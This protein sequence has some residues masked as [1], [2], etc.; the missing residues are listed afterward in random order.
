MRPIQA[1]DTVSFDGTEVTMLDQT[2]LPV[3]QVRLTI[4]DTPQMHEAIRSLRVRGAPAIGVAAAFGLW[5]GVRDLPD[6]L[7]RDEAEARLR[8][9]QTFLAG[10]RPTA[11][12][13]TWALE[14]CAAEALRAPGGTAA[15]KQAALDA[16]IRLRANE[17]A[18]TRQ[19]GE[20]GA[21]LLMGLSGV[22]THCN[23]GSAATV[24]L[25]TALAPIYVAAER[26]HLLRV[27]ADETRPLLQG[28]RITAWELQEAGVP[29]TVITDS[30]AAV[31][32]RQGKVG[33]VI[34]GC[35]RVAANGDVANKIGTYGVALL[36]RAH[37]LPFYVAGPTSTIDLATPDGDHIE[38]E[39]R[40]PHEVTHHGGVPMAPEGVDV[41][42]PAFDVTPA[43][44]V[45]A[46]ITEKGVVYPPYTQGLKDVKA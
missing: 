12:N 28:A 37:G 26:G 27:F 41:F 17:E 31:V 32:M 42:N 34:V 21:G 8:G 11:V 16:A 14:R 9:E 7:P 33:A 3:Q 1:V 2:L 19:I 46:I 39:Q 4:R 44:Y 15:L 20:H 43:E 36:A 29:V 22:L 40:A 10:A 18:T 13:L 24:G 38:I 35:D 30:M 6:D 5:L 23:A 45:S 25:G